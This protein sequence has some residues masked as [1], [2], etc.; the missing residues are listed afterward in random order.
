M[1]VVNQLSFDIRHSPESNDHQVRI[2]V[3]NIDILGKEQLGLDPPDLIDALHPAAKGDILVGRC[4]CGC[5]GCGDVFAR[6]TK[7]EDCI[8]WHY[9]D[10]TFRFSAVSYK[11]ALTKLATNHDWED[12][13]RHVERRLNLALSTYECGAKENGFRWVSTRVGRNQLTYSFVK[14]NEQ[15]LLVIHWGGATFEDAFTRHSAVFDGR[16]VVKIFEDAKK[17]KQKYMT[18]WVAS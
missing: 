12:I 4:N 2:L 13:N 10:Q 7:Q 14:N 15:K 17:T 6:I 1:S 16:S 3:D 9:E 8:V 11:A 18:V 5:L